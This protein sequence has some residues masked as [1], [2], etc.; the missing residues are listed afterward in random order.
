[1]SQ[2]QIYIFRDI[3]RAFLTILAGLLI[4]AILGQG[5]SQ[6]DLIVES[7]QSAGVY[8]KVVMLGT[9]KVLALLAPLGLYVAIAWSLSRIQRD[10]EL[11]VASAAGMTRWQVASP[12]L[13]LATVVALVHLAV[14]LWG[15]PHLQRELRETMHDARADLAS[16]LIRPGEFTTAGEKLTFFARE[17]SGGNLKGLFISDSGLSEPADYLAETGRVIQIDGRP[18]LLMNNGQIHQV[19]PDDGLSILEFDQYVFD[20][21]PFVREE[22]DIVLKASDRFLPELVRIDSTNYFEASNQ[23]E[24]QAEANYRLTSP[25]LNL[26]M[27]LLAIFAVLGGTYR[28]TGNL[29]RIALTGT[30]AM[31]IMFAHLSAQAAAVETPDMNSAQWV[32]PIGLLAGLSIWYFN[33]LQLPRFKARAA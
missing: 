1:M 29:Q 18:A 2:I 26:V 17:N 23:R 20:L 33:S 9:P 14:N 5:L 31:G 3:L 15:Q 19:E 16:M 21:G 13:R 10:S 11:V 28:R 27:A 24:F 7:R 25:L 6:T 4:I 8:F 12:A 22:T 30:A 32:I